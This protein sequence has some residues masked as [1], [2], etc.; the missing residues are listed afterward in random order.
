MPRVHP[1]LRVW[2]GCCFFTAGTVSSCS[3][4][5]RFSHVWNGKAD[6]RS[7]RFVVRC[8][9][10]LGERSL[11]LLVGLLW[12]WSLTQAA[13]PPQKSQVPTARG[14][15]RHLTNVRQLTFGRKNAEAY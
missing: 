3:K 2:H 5:D 10:W 6:E 11:F 1:R 8:R 9:K 14:T 15:E 7:R 4:T 12:C 13:E